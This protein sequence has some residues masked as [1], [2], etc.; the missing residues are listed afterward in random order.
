MKTNDSK[1]VLISV[2]TV[3]KDAGSTIEKTLRSVIEQDYTSFEYIVIDGQSGDKTFEIIK[4]YS[5]NIN[6][7]L[8][9][10]DSGIYDAMNKAIG[11]CSGEWTIFM[12]AGDVFADHTV[13]RKTAEFLNKNCDVVYGDIYTNKAGNLSL[14]KSPHV[15]KNIHRMPFCHQAVFTKTKVLKKYLFDEKYC[16]SAD[17]KFF[18][19]L[20]LN[21]STF[22]KANIP[23]TIFDRSGISN[24]QRVKGL[25]ENAAI[26]NELDNFVTKLTFLPRLYF[27]IYWNKLR[28]KTTR[29]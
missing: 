23:I 26:I 24:T 29:K 12:N 16:L 18:K 3:C 17:F 5:S 28:K 15:I 2:V 21:K 1:N 11:L 27:V 19:Q 10:K 20:I 13:L 8:S 4:K 6:I 7:F 14:K 22:Q 25:L 9:E